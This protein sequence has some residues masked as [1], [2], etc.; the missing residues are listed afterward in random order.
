MPSL[1]IIDTVA[2]REDKFPLGCEIVLDIA[3][4]S[5]WHA[6]KTITDKGTAAKIGVLE[7]DY[8]LIGFS[9]YH[10]L[11]YFN[12]APILHS[13]GIPLLTYDRSKGDPVICA[14]GAAVTSNPFP[15]AD[16]FDFILL[17][18]AEEVFP[19]IL[20]IYS[21][22]NKDRFL[23]K[24]AETFDSVLVPKY[25]RDSYKVAIAKDIN[26]G[27]LPPA[28]GR[29]PKIEL[30]RGCRFN[31]SFC[32]QSVIPYRENSLSAIVPILYQYAPQNV[33]LSANTPASYSEFLPLLDYCKQEK[34]YPRGLSERLSSL[35]LPVLEKMRELNMIQANIGIEGYSERLRQ[36]IRKPISKEKLIAKLC[37]IQRYI[38]I[39]SVNFI[40]HLPTVE[41]D[42]VLEFKATM[43]SVLSQRDQE[44]ALKT[45]YDFTTTP[46]IARPH[47]KMELCPYREEKAESLAKEAR[48][49][50][51]DQ[52]TGVKMKFSMSAARRKMEFLLSRGDESFR[53]LF[54]KTHS[55]YP[56]YYFH[57]TFAEKIKNCFADSLNVDYW[58]S[59][60]VSPHW[61]RISF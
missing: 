46:L 57:Q 43:E 48:I 39:L 18:D 31:C 16:F 30:A 36:M 50:L 14:G 60:E 53:D 4:K 29:Q 7:K 47:T 6:D 37:Q 58:L 20:K 25:P 24:L 5:G 52:F 45:G 1:T 15:V 42:D 59:A 55:K 38:P 3:R 44:E 17:G 2:R 26:S 32:L 28:E 13:F 8:D 10:Q 22:S 11:Q 23:R 21:K 33:F 19:Q 51:L 12:I 9:L 27:I 41:I 34:I 54:I 61:H 56:T 40:S 35:S 49:S